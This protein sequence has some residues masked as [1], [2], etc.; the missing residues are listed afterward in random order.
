VTTTRERRSAAVA[1]GLLATTLLAA[2]I[3]PWATGG[4]LT[5]R[6]IAAPLLLLGALAAVAAA[7]LPTSPLPRRP[8]PGR[9]ARPPHQCAHCAA[10]DHLA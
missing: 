4:T 7:R 6:L 9:A 3:L 10:P 8:A 2:G 1:L 5:V